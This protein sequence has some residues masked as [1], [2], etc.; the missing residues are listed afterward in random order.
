MGKIRAKRRGARS[1]PEPAGLPTTTSL[2]KPM[3][4]TEESAPHPQ[5]ILHR[6]SAYTLPPAMHHIY[7][8]IATVEG[9]SFNPLQL[10]SHDVTERK[11][12][13]NSLSHLL[14]DTTQRT[15][16][17]EGRVVRRLAPLLLDQ[18]MEIREAAAG[19]LR[20]GLIIIL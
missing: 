13:C 10:A 2:V 6:V 20:W 5:P 15:R 12:A 7:I 14:G 1:R 19:A 16:L 8:C 3:E 9:H 18:V 11:W 17:I 4:E